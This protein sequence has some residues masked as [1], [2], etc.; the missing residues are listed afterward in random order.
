MADTVFV[1][2]PRPGKVSLTVGVPLRPR[3]LQMGSQAFFDTVNRV[4]DGLFGTDSRE[5]GALA[6]AAE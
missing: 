6:A 5:A 1:M 4:R 3:T 2:S